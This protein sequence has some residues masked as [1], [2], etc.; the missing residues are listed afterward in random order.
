[1]I[2]F[3]NYDSAFFIVSEQKVHPSRFIVSELILTFNGHEIIDILFTD[4]LVDYCKMII[5]IELFV[6]NP[7]ADPHKRFQQHLESSCFRI[8]I[9][10][11]FVALY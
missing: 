8:F 7:V 4:F 9:K 10:H 1:M 3:I 6:R 11:L 5:E 2:E